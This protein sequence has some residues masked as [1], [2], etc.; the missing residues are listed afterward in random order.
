MIDKTKI[1]GFQ[2]FTIKSNG[3]RLRSIVGEVGVSLPFDPADTQ[4]LNS[5]P[6]HRTQAL[7]DTGASNSVVTKATAKALNLQPTSLARV[8]HAGGISDVNVYLVNLYLPNGLN[9]SG[10][11]VTECEDTEGHFGVIIG[12]DIITL[13]DFAVTNVGENTT[14]SY[15][16]PSVKTIDYVQESHQIN[17]MGKPNSS[18][19]RND[20]CPCGSGKKYKNCHGRNVS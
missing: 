4:T 9:I 6:I 12:M 15:R 11:N 13:G 10:V 7:W 3:G 2:A 20:Q 14:V 18:I 17:A 8:N 5:T 1:P 16:F 19:G